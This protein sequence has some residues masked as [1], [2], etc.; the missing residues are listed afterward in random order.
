MGGRGVWIHGFER[1]YA[2]CF[3]HTPLSP[4]SPH[5]PSPPPLSL[6]KGKALSQF[7]SNLTGGTPGSQT[8]R[9]IARKAALDGGLAKDLWF[10]YLEQEQPEEWVE[11]VDDDCVTAG[12]CVGGRV[13]VS[14][15]VM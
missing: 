1:K 7:I 14:C 9:F 15:V 4:S 6:S 13:C 10:W 8:Y 5:P 3:L 12:V 11:Y 2:A